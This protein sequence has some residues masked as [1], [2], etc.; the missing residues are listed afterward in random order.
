MQRGRWDVSHVKRDSLA[1]LYT[2]ESLRK[3]PTSAGGGS[4]ACV[5]PGWE[6]ELRVSL[7]HQRHLSS[8]PSSAHLSLSLEPISCFATLA[9]GVLCGPGTEALFW[10]RAKENHDN[11]TRHT[12]NNFLFCFPFRRMVIGSQLLRCMFLKNVGV[13]YL[14][15]PGCEGTTSC[16]SNPSPPAA[17]GG[18]A[19]GLPT[20]YADGQ[21]APWPDGTPLIFHKSLMR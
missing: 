13:S 2:C 8:W 20:D 17:G 14:L 18:A 1:F 10:G 7:G 15:P 19:S 9:S 11:N 4:W 16:C 6:S 3:A 12:M 21:P 5:R